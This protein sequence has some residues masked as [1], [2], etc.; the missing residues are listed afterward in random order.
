M[1]SIPTLAASIAAAA[2]AEA[3]AE[4]EAT[5]TG[6]PTNVTMLAAVRHRYGAPV[7]PTTTQTPTPGEGEVLV[8]V[9]AAGV[10][11]G[12]CH[13]HTGTPYLMRLVG[14]GLTRPKQPV[15]GMDLSGVVAAVGPD[16]SRFSPG[17]EV[18]GIGNGTFAH[19][20]IAAADKLSHKPNSLSHTL[21]AALPISGGTA[22]QA[23][24][25]HGRVE[26]GHRV[27][28]LGA[29]GGVGS[30][31]VQLAKVFGAEVTGVASGPKLDMVRALGADVVIDYRSDDPLAA[32]GCYDVIIDIGGR[33]PIRRLRRALA[34]K[35]TLVIVGGE[36]GNRITGGIG[37]QLSAAAISPFI[38]QRLMFFIAGEG[39]ESTDTLAHLAST[40]AITPK[41][42]HQYRLDQ[43]Q[44]A[45]EDLA[46]GR[47]KG[48]GVIQIADELA[49]ALPK[50][51]RDEN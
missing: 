43:V 23:V 21:A 12:T 36:G 4:A 35:G 29:S 24:R 50:E 38:S 46:T 37:R 3:E 48:K 41:V 42:N 27:L 10:D 22:L 14:F 15:L 28:I 47:V 32:A 34:E 16:V 1:S 7:E 19:Y 25:D 45:L 17:D 31:A 40:G 5:R 13:V 18:F 33:N 11:R 30:Y 39:R 26:P 49:D 6:V 2:A 8:K 44:D 20:A 51:G 9:H